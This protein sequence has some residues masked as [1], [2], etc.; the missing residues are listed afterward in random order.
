MGQQT[1]KTISAHDL[2]A[3]TLR[4][5]KDGYRLVAISCTNIGIKKCDLSLE[6][7]NSLETDK[8]KVSENSISSD[9]FMEL[10]Y[11]FDKGYDLLTLRFDAETED[12]IESISI[13]Y[14]YSFLYENEIKELFGVKIKDISLDFN[15]SLYK[16]PVKTP[17]A[18]KEE[19]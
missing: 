6:S 13:I 12:E 14:P 7:I 11:S 16:I 9:N 10:S 19:K 15:N 5:E 3:E 18:T 17:F 2:L 1:I 4:L 8:T